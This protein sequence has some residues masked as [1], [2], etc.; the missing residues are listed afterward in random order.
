MDIDN[1][2]EQ[3]N[4]YSAANT[5]TKTPSYTLLNFGIGTDIVRKQKTVC[6]LFIALN[7]AT[8]KADQS[9]LSRLK[10]ADENYV[11]GRTGVNNMGRNISFKIIFP[12]EIKYG[13]KK[14]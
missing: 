6:S 12:L 14:E 5:E 8:D 4:I 3:N 11:T 7:N 2:F 9:H 13:S 10:Y 1:F